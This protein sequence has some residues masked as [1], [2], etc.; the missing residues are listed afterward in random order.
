MHMGKLT[1]M[2]RLAIEEQLRAEDICARKVQLYMSVTRDPSVQALLQQMAE[3]GQR[4][5]S[6]LNSLLQ[7]AGLASGV[8][9]H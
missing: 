4:H 9:Q 7:D 8:A 3:K 1:E 5:V 6:T 2:E